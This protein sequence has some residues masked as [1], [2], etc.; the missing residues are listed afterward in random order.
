MLLLLA[1]LHAP[2][3]TAWFCDGHMAVAQIARDSGIMTPA[4]LAAA[5]TLISYLNADYPETGTTFTEAACW[6]DDLKSHG[7]AQE[8][9][10]HY[11]DLPVCRLANNASCPPPYPADNAVWAIKGAQSTVYSPKALTLDKA[12]QLRFMVHFV[13]DI[14]QPLHAATY[15]SAQF[16]GGDRGG[17][18]WPI[19]GF[20]WTSE[21]HA[22]WDGGLGQW[23]DDLVRP[24][25]A[26]GTAWVAALAAQ[27]MG[28]YPVSAL[29][30]EIAVYNASTWAAESHA[31]AED[32]VYTAP[33]APALIPAA[34][35]EKG[36]GMVLKQL[37]IAGY[38]LANQMCVPGGAG[39]PPPPR[40]AACL[41]PLAAMRAFSLTQGR[42]THTRSHAL[43]HIN[44]HTHTHTACCSQFI[45][46]TPQEAVYAKL[47]VA[48]GLVRQ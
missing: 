19:S 5:D 43:M 11:L 9:D 22:L 39:P 20:A 25:N 24:L 18:D 10:W 6:A 1:L 27:V 38:R 2:L 47:P 44:T 4:T 26:T 33:Q 16:P 21:L 46:T 35:I 41:P 48:A 36:K 31:L 45:F 7:A 8:A 12:R 28:L 15:F 42:P 23:A 13:G 17:N 14:H 32:F 37:A 30:P 3:A 34:Y 40:F 29:Q